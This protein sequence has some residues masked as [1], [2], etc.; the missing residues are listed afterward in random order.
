ME[1]AE[2][3]VRA[4]RKKLHGPL[5]DLAE[6]VPVVFHDRPSPEILGEEFEP[7]LLGLFVGAPVNEA[8]EGR[9]DV[10][11][12]ILL[13]IEEL[14]DFAEGDCDAYRKEVRVTYLHELGHYL[15]WDED[16]VARRGL[17]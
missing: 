10:P 1:I 4:A 16:E 14:F 15:G 11:A 12:H 2:Q 9:A 7:D 8:V 13:F 3:E 5:R 17:E 6:S